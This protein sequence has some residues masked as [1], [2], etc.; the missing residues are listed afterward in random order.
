MDTFKTFQL[1]YAL[2]HWKRQDK[3]ITIAQKRRTNL[4]EDVLVAWKRRVAFKGGHSI[5][6]TA[7]KSKVW[8][9]LLKN[10]KAK[11]VKKFRIESAS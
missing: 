10:R 5:H 6:N 3:L 2:A 11:K 8:S 7:L 4:M 9:C 1:K